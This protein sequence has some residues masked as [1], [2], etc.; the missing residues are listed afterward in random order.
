MSLNGAVG[1]IKRFDTTD[2]VYHI[3]FDDGAPPV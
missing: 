2:D 1:Y 3:E